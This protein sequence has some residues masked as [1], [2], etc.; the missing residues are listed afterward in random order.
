MRDRIEA[1]LTGDVTKRLPF[2]DRLEL[3]YRHHS[4]SQTLP[5]PYQDMN[6]YD[7]HKN[8]GMGR[9]KFVMPQA[10]KLKG[11]ELVVYHNREM[12]LREVDP[13]YH[14]FPAL[15]AP[16]FVPREKVGDTEITFITPRGKLSIKYTITESTRSNS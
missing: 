11:V 4:S 10:L 2:V 14:E 8:L 12:L 5:E 13:V 16:D 9:Q 3:W 1:V 7:I 15:N 6:M